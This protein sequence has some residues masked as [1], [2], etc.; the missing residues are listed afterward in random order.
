VSL[1]TIFYV[2]NVGHS[3]VLMCLRYGCVDTDGCD[4]FSKL[5]ER[6][7]MRVILLVSR[8]H[9][10]SYSSPPYSHYN[11]CGP[12]SS[13]WTNPSQPSSLLMGGLKMVGC[14]L[15]SMYAH[16]WRMAVSPVIT[17]QTPA[18]TSKRYLCQSTP[19]IFFFL[20]G[21]YI[22]ERNQEKNNC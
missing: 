12:V 21:S 11:L 7:E 3:V 20:R 9:C 18:T 15:R 17:K 6:F 4:T 22:P 13:C 16:D 10:T 1:S 8:G 19:S 5:R 14:N 2:S